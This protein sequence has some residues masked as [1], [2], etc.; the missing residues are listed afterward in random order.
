VE[1][2]YLSFTKTT[3]TLLIQWGTTTFSIMVI[4][5]T[6]QCGGVSKNVLVS[7]LSI[8]LAVALLGVMAPSMIYTQ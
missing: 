5:K 8:M 6:T 2:D 1:V 7:V 3:E 4:S